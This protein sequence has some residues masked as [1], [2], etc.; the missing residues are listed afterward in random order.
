[1]RHGHRGRVV[2]GVLELGCWRGADG[3]KRGR[4]FG[5]VVWWIWVLSVSVECPVCQICAW[6]RL[7]MREDVAVVF[8]AEGPHLPLSVTIRKVF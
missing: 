3:G 8:G 7:L 2:V 4:G 6:L 5:E 1:M